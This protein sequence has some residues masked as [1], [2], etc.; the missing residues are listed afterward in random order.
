MRLVSDHS[1]AVFIQLRTD[2]VVG[3]ELHEETEIRERADSFVNS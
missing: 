1:V 2:L 3:S